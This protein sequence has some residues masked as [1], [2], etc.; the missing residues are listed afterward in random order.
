MKKLLIIISIISVNSLFAQNTFQY[1]NFNAKP[2]MEDAIAN[3][4]EEYWGDAK[5]KSGGIQI[6]R[7]AHGNEPWSHRVILFGEVGK[8][9][10]EEGDEKEFEWELFIQKLNH[11]IE[12]WGT[13]AAGRFM[14]IEG[15]SWIDFPYVQIYNLKLNDPGAFKSAHDKIVKQTAKTRGD[16]PVAF[17]TYDIGGGENISHW[18]AVGSSD[19]NDLMSQKA[20][21]D[22]Y[23]KEWVE[24]SKNNG[25]HTIP[26]NYTIQVL[27]A[28]TN[29]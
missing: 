2:G 8:I 27:A 17:G 6:E 5:F 3:L 15:G 11:F 21:N 24:W 28:F 20:L 10:R 12:E 9:G 7:Y 13:S 1:W 26:S 23:E 14:S 4:T 18:V 19:F 25:G 29:E 22:Q 16:R